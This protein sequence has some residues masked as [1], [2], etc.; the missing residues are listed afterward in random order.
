MPS[1]YILV[2][3]DEPDIRELVKEILEDEG[4]QVTVAEDGE[5]ALKKLQLRRPD[6]MLLDIWMPDIDGITLLKKL[7]EDEQNHKLC[8]PVIM[9]SGHA[10]IDTA[11]ESTRLGAYD[12][13]EKP[14]SLAKLLLTVEHALDTFKL[15]KEN[16]GL[17]QQLPEVEELIGKSTHILELREQ[18]EATAHYEN[19]VL[20]N[21]Q[22]GTGKSNIA[23]LIHQSSNRKNG[24]FIDISMMSIDDDMLTKELFG[25]EKDGKIKY[26]LIE[27]ANNG[28]LFINDIA[29]LDPFIQGRI[30]RLIETHEI[31]RVDGTAPV[32][33]NTRIIAS[34][35]FDLKNLVTQQQFRQ[36]LY[37]QLSLGKINVPSLL[38]HR[39]DIPELLNYYLERYVQINK[40]TY[41]HF[42]I[43]AIN[44]LRNYEWPGNLFELQNLVQRLL[45]DGHEEIIDIEEVEI[46]LSKYHYKEEESNINFQHNPLFEL[47][48][49]EAREQFEKAYL[50]YRLNQENGSV[51]KVAKFADVERTHLYRKIRSLGIDVKV[52]SHKKK[53]D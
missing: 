37:Q 47:S 43:G 41:R 23:R 16:Q 8:F 13:L 45:I 18:I 14:L 26:G 24:P 2:V 20:V 10:T 29:L 40:F 30:E 51:G 6:V 33:V 34:T 4:Y 35:E 11:V 36:D 32:K 39:E 9:M 19:H 38:S 28:I 46:A 52:F 48:L 7:T 42:S 3:D 22:R 5:T 17:K 50:E 27:Q 53:Q 25:S 1:D 12:F 15:G 49:K 21:G 44:R 31:Y